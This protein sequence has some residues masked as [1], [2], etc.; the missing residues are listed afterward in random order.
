[1]NQKIKYTNMYVN[2]FNLFYDYLFPICENLI[3]LFRKLRN[4]TSELYQPN[5]YAEG[6]Q[7]DLMENSVEEE[8]YVNLSKISNH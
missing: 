1:M 5:K 2:N 6:S 8:A 4:G 7:H 3:L